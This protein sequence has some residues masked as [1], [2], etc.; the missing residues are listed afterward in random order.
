MKAAKLGSV[1]AE[2][3]LGELYLKNN[4]KNGVAWYNKAIK[5]GSNDA[6]FALGIYYPLT[7]KFN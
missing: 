3:E 5:D 1:E 6:R 2:L 7:L 4:D